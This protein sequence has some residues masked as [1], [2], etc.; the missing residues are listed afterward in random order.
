MCVYTCVHSLFAP[1]LNKQII[2]V[3]VLCLFFT[4]EAQNY[5]CYLNVHTHCIVKEFLGEV[6]R[7][8]VGVALYKLY[9]ATTYYY[10]VYSILLFHTHVCTFALCTR[11]CTYELSS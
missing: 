3:R 10:L 2:F 4:L 5:C 6:R 7:I 1:K 11:V 8:T 9:L